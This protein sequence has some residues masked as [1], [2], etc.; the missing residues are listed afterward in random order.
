M[1]KGCLRNQDTQNSHDQSILLS[2]FEYEI[3]VSGIGWIE[4]LLSIYW[5]QVMTASHQE[6]ASAGIGELLIP[7]DR[8][9]CRQSYIHLSDLPLSGPSGLTRCHPSC[10]WTHSFYRDVHKV[11]TITLSASLKATFSLFLGLSPRSVFLSHLANFLFLLL[12]FILTLLL[13][14]WSLVC[15][16]S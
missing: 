14:L 13:C 10:R 3:R 9:E 2:K 6:M 1:K 4:Y 12:P 11:W 15:S 5:P 16:F 8:L 7:L